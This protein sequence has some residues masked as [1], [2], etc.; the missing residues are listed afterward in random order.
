MILYSVSFD[1]MRSKIKKELSMS[2][3]FTGDISQKSA[4]ATTFIFFCLLGLSMAFFVFANDETTSKSIFEDSDKD[5]LS[6]DE[7]ILYNTDPLKRDTDGDGYTD[8]V[9]VGSGYDPLKPAPGDKLIS[10]LSE[11]RTD[12]QSQVEKENLTEAFSKEITDILQEGTVEGGEV[13]ID[14][15]NER[16]QEVLSQTYTEVTLPEVTVD[17]VKVKKEIKN[18]KGDAKKQKEKEE[19]VEYLTVMAYIMANNSPKSFHNEKDLGALLSSLSS[20]SLSALALGNTTYIEKL[21]ERGEKTLKEIKDVEVPRAML[22][23]HMKALKMAKFTVE[24]KKEVG[25][26][27]NQN[28]PLGQIASLSKVQGFLGVVTDFTQEVA[29]KLSELG[30]SEIPIDL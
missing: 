30:I 6:N 14:N 2:L 27:N 1:V 10:S 28:D 17:E 5:G 15:I 16:V 21:S 3:N 4:R 26:G 9:E 22:E 18:L 25:S 12:A 20:E 8:G 7:E 23:V 13:T 11:D 24:L 29:T 19:I